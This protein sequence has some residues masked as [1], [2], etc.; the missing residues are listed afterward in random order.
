MWF[1][2]WR[3][4]INH[5]TD[6]A[7]VQWRGNWRYLE[8]VRT[9]L[10]STCV[11][12][13]HVS[14]YGVIGS[15]FEYCQD[16]E[17]VFQAGQC[18]VNSQLCHLLWGIEIGN[19]KLRRNTRKRVV[20]G[21]Y[22]LLCQGCGSQVALKQSSLA[23]SKGERMFFWYHRCLWAVLFEKETKSRLCLG[24]STFSYGPV[25]WEQSGARSV[26]RMRVKNSS[27]LCEEPLGRM[28]G[29]PLEMGCHVSAE[30]PCLWSV[31]WVN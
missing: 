11:K 20:Q 24:R 31:Q 21:W 12:L 26:G 15:A 30:V 7:P 17:C 18:W 29:V 22:L 4:L 13:A 6:C 2:Q 3:Q 25:R 9:D 5:G 27:V 10:A 14:V 8:F 28:S 1:V 19:F 23:D 16:W